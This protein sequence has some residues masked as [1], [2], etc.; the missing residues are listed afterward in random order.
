M[1]KT[2]QLPLHVGWVSSYVPKRCGI[3]TFSRDLIGGIELADPTI[4]ISISA[5][6]SDADELTYGPYVVTTTNNSNPES[7]TAAG[8]KLA[9]MQLNALVV[10]HEFGLFG[11]NLTNFERDGK[12]IHQPLGDNIFRLI[13]AADVPVIVTLHTVLPDPDD[14]RR[15][16]VWKLADKAAAMVTMTNGA[17]EV[18]VD[19]YGIDAEKIRVIPHG[20]PSVTPVDAKSS[21]AELGLPADEPIMMITGLIGGNKGIDI[22]IN[23]LPRIL[24]EYPK[25]KLYVVGQTHPDILAYSGETYR[26]SLME[27]ARELGVAD[28]LVFVNKYLPVEE[29]V[30]YLRASDLYLTLHGDPEQ[31]ASGTLAYA[32]GAGLVSIST[33]YR[34][35]Q[36]VLS[37]DRGLLVPFNDDNAFSAAVLSILGDPVRYAAMRKRAQAYGASMSWPIVGRS[38]SD[39]IHSVARVVQ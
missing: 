17:K 29:L 11:G 6:E 10:Q 19:K 24:K 2:K 38:Y 31:A 9:G 16:I 27:L 25:L 23:A 21:K 18:L 28:S 4:R 8:K 13:N 34:Y 30:K 1:P 3:A 15:E 33:P 14:E 20:V 37:D 7:F 39:L 35:A 12:A 22:A 5:A 26:E 32:M 36:E